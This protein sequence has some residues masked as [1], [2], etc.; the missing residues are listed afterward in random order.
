MKSHTVEYVTTGGGRKGCGTSHVEFIP[1]G[2]RVTFHL[3]RTMGLPDADKIFTIPFEALDA[4]PAPQPDWTERGGYWSNERRR[5][6][7]ELPGTGKH[8]IFHYEDAVESNSSPWSDEEVFGPYVE[9]SPESSGLSLA[10]YEYETY[11]IGYVREHNYHISLSTEPAP[12]HV[13]EEMAS[14]AE[15]IGS[16]KLT[17]DDV[18]ALATCQDLETELFRRFGKHD[19]QDYPGLP[20]GPYYWIS[21]QICEVIRRMAATPPGCKART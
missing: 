5:F 19:L 20:K 12:G 17:P 8:L 11:A 21:P 13:E 7:V 9:A 6:A 15:E 1:D 10:L 4:L 2:V 3:Q 14:P 16:I 18:R